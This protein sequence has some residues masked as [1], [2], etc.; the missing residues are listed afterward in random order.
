MYSS[1]VLVSLE[2][3]TAACCNMFLKK[4]QNAP[5][6]SEHPPVIRGG[7]MSIRA[8]LDLLSIPQV[9]LFRRRKVVYIYIYIYK[10][11]LGQHKAVTIYSFEL[12][13]QNIH[14]MVHT[15][16]RTVPS[17]SVC[18]YRTRPFSLGVGNERANA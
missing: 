13:N 9:S 10:K 2:R 6:P 3:T 7:K 11:D 1:P 17:Q 14:A 16:E 15:H 5:R 4:N 8:H 18:L 12:S